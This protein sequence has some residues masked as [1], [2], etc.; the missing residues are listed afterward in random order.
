M[1]AVIND[2]LYFL[3]LS[4]SGDVLW[5][6]LPLG[7]ATIVMLIYFEKYRDESPGW[8]TYV[9]NSLVFL[10]VSVIL[11]RYIFGINGAGAINF[12]N[13]PVKSITAITL[14]ILGIIIL[15]LNFEHYLPEKIANYVSSPLTL[16]LIAYIIIIFVYSTKE[17][18]MVVFLSLI[19]IYFLLLMILNILR[20]PIK[21]FFMKLKKMKQVEKLDEIVKEN[22]KF[23]SKEQEIKKE[24]KQMVKLRLKKLDKQKKEAIKLKKIVKKG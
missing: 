15:F 14:L 6:V 22:K 7:I 24:K 4:I 17:S 16:N 2:I 11:F 5:T 3:N 19:I 23:K 10:F 21:K 18:S 8:N 12:I 1:V 9:A 13:F 20:I